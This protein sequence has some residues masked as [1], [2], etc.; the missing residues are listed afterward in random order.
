MVPGDREFPD[1]DEG[2]SPPRRLKNLVREVD[3]VLYASVDTHRSAT[4]IT[5]VD[6]AGNVVAR[7]H[8]ASSFDGIRDLFAGQEQPIKA[9]VEATYNWGLI[10]DWLAEIADEMILAHSAMPRAIVDARIKSDEIDSQTL[11]HLLRADR[12]TRAPTR[13]GVDRSTPTRA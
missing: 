11:A 7:K 1:Y 9:V 13:T 12:C 2:A 6:D 8:V 3:A 4:H 10:Y 5:I